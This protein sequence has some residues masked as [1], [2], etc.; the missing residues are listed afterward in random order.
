MVILWYLFVIL[1]HDLYSLWHAFNTSSVV[2][3]G[4]VIDERIPIF[5]LI[6]RT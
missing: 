6:T 2:Y 5:G 3:H 1:E 4:Y